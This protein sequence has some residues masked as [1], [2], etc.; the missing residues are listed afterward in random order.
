VTE[1]VKQPGKE[2]GKMAYA[3]I[4]ACLSVGIALGWSLCHFVTK[5]G[6]VSSKKIATKKPQCTLRER[7]RESIF[8]IDHDLIA[9]R[10]PDDRK[11]LVEAAY[12]LRNLD[13][14]AS[15]GTLELIRDVNPRNKAPQ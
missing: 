12:R 6:V 10:N 14:R 9:L 1:Q 2:K 11:D 5:K 15:L 8:T 4:P 3:L 7:V 13:L